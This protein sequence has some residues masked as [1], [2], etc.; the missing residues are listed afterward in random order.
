MCIIDAKEEG[1]M[2]IYENIIVYLWLVPVIVLIVIPLLWWVFAKLYRAVARTR[3]AKVEGCIL[4][5]AGKKAV[6]ENFE[7][8]NSPRIRLDEGHAYIDEKSD[9]CKADVSNISKDGICLQHVPEAMDLKSNPLRVLFRTPE[10]DY[11]FMVK[12]IWKKLTSKGYVIGAEIDQ[13]PSG[14]K[15]L[16][17]GFNQPCAAR[18]T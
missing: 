17:K 1:A 11:T 8:R 3:L 14:W 16:L 15:N 6:T 18:D 13:A 4:E 7:N 10:K 5:R 2:D 9:C 12:P